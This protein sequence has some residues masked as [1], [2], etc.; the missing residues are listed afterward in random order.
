LY[1]TTGTG[2]PVLG[3]YA[4][5]DELQIDNLGFVAASISEKWHEKFDR[6]VL[7]YKPLRTWAGVLVNW[8]APAPV[9]GPADEDDK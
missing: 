9:A 3:D 8:T 5:F 4:R 6:L 2:A 1:V 7:R